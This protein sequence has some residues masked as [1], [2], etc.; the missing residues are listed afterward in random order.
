MTSR[1]A[2]RRGIESPAGSTPDINWD[3]ARKLG[4]IDEFDPLPRT[5]ERK[6]KEVRDE[7]IHRLLD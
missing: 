2:R 6:C 3:H 4:R 5:D 1:T 7:M